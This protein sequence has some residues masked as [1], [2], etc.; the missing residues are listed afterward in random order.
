MMQIVK[1][2]FSSWTNMHIYEVL[3]TKAMA[4]AHTARAIQDAKID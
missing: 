3:F 1:V 4:K 2:A